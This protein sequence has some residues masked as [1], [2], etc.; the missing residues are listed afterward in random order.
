MLENL[1]GHWLFY[2]SGYLQTL[3]LGL[4]ISNSLNMAANGDQAIDKKDA[5]APEAAA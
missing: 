4:V 1:T 3:G 2:T 5:P